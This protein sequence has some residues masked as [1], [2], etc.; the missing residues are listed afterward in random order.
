MSQQNLGS[1]EVGRKWLLK[2]LGCPGSFVTGA[3]SRKP[4]WISSPGKNSKSFTFTLQAFAA[5]EL[6]LLV[7]GSLS[8]YFLFVCW[9]EVSCSPGWPVT[10]HRIKNDL[11]CLILLPKPFEVETKSTGP[12]HP[13]C[14]VLGLEPKNFVIPRTRVLPTKLHIPRP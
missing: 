5:L 3:S 7:L 9:L 10:H 4:P 1:W 13:V 11:E 2:L 6:S 12:P 14:A 8:V